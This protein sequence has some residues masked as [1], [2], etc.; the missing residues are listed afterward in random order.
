MSDRHTLQFLV[1]LIDDDT[2]EVRQEILRELGNYG[3]DLEEDLQEF[4]DDLDENKLK[5]I[6]PILQ[7]NRREW[8]VNNWNEWT[9]I[10][11]EY[12]SLETA[13][14][15]IAQFQYGPSI[16]KNLWYQLNVLSEDF[17]NKFPYGSE[18]DLANYLF[19]ELMIS[20]SKL[21][22]YNPLNSNLLYAVESKQGLPITLAILYMLVGERTGLVIEGC[23]FPGHFLAK[24]EF[25][26][27]VILVDCFNGGRMIY[28]SE[29]LNMVK[30]S[31]EAIM[32]IINSHTSTRSIVRRVLNNLSNA[33]KQKGDNTN[34]EFFSNLI[35]S[36]AW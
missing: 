30:L 12:E 22:Y 5:I 15:L 27:E 10:R 7:E 17:K 26:K 36:T 4:S 11:D 1:D 31:Y 16:N 29:L 14:N 18:F 8:L 13:M 33:Y 9:Y 25:D 23:N 34:S 20:G 28:E 19:K 24:I 3:S 6:A 2:A 21:D 32:K 35:K